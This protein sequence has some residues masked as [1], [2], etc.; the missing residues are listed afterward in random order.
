M[1]WGRALYEGAAAR[2]QVSAATAA[3]GSKTF[4]GAGVRAAT[5]AF[6]L[7]VLAVALLFN[8]VR[9]LWAPDE[10]RYVAAALEMLRRHDF[11]GIFLND[12]TA[13]FTKPP[14]TYW[15]LAAA[16]AAFGPSEFVARLPNALAFAATACLLL[17]AGRLL[18]P[19]MPML[20]AVLYATTWLPFLGAHFVTTDTLV[21]LF[22][23][24][25]GVSFLHLQAGIAPRRAA[26]GVWL[27]FGLA[28]LTKGPPT[29]LALPVFVGWLAFRRDVV[30]LRKLF[31]SAGVP[32][33]AVIAFGWFLLAD[34][35]FPGLLDYLLS[36]E[37]GSRV[38]SQAFERN[39]DWYDGIVIYLPT[40]AIGAL[41][42]LPAWI[43]MRRSRPFAPA[44]ASPVDRLLLAWVAVPFCVLLMAPSRLPL[45]LLPLFVP[46]ALMAARVLAPLDL[47]RRRTQILLGTWCFALALARALPAYVDMHVPVDDRA[48]AEALS[49]AL[50]APPDEIAFIKTD[51]RYGL[52]FYL[53]SEI[54]RLELPGE[55]SRLQTQDMSSE[56]Q[57]HEGCRVL[58]VNDWNV[59]RVER[60]LDARGMP[61][62]RVHD[63]QG[64]AVIAQRTPDCEAYAGL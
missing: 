40:L 9:P 61:Y 2:R 59:G 28:F 7:L 29:L 57:E 38:A 48:L 12:D 43:L 8:G 56:M 58:L 3:V 31:V 26:L 27:G 1:D 63:V 4:A 15:S 34:A 52:R 21:A 60:F 19:R 35:R 47:R 13:H 18:V 50:P 64:Y 10:G 51:P 25:A 54:E 11:I 46:L 37:V 23:T 49:A 22:T 17:P 41:P 45:Y 14:L 53:G 24:L 62:K 33:F 55:S 20:P 32:L 44:L 36:A 30:A 39:G 5:V 6:F 42:W 16:F